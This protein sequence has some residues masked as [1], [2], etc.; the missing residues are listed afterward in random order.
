M[1]MPTMRTVATSVTN[2]VAS[3]VPYRAG[4]VPLVGIRLEC[5]TPTFRCGTL[6]LRSCTGVL[7]SLQLRPH[8]LQ[9]CC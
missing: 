1:L 5:L 2:S 8:I 3:A 7:F 6:C 4:G 9:L